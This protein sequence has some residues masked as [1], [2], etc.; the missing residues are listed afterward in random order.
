MSIDSNCVSP[1]RVLFGFVFRWFLFFQ[2][3]ILKEPVRLC[4]LRLSYKNIIIGLFI[5]HLYKGSEI[6]EHL[7]VA[8]LVSLGYFTML[9]LPRLHRVQ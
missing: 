7:M 1:P 8:G 9:S 6:M 3:Q 2:F 4:D 5:N